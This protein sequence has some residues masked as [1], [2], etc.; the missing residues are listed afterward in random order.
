MRE[1][2]YTY[3]KAHNEANNKLL[4]GKGNKKRKCGQ[5]SKKQVRHRRKFLMIMALNLI[6]SPVK[7]NLIK[8][9]ITN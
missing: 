6:N 9:V 4:L 2:G 7:L 3:E 8:I 1:K 5:N